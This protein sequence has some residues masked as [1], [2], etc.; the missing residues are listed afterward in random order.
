[1]SGFMNLV[2][3]T[4]KWTLRDKI[5]H[6]FLGSSLVIFL[7][8]P[9]FS[10]FSMRQVQELSITLSLSFTSFVLLVLT[11]LLG[12][13]SV[14]RD[15]EQ[16]YTSSVLGM[17]LSR[18]SFVL[19]KFTGI[20]FFILACAV[21][22][23]AASFFVVA[24]SSAQY[25]SQQP[26]HWGAM[27]IAITSDSLKYVLLAA[28]ALLFSSLSTSF[29]LPFFGTIAMYLAGSG[30]QEVY[31]YIT[32]ELGKDISFPVR[33]ILKALYYA[34]PNFSSFNL[35]VQAIY[36]LPMSFS[37]LS[38]TICYFLIYTAILLLGAIRMFSRRELD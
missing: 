4:I 30:S 35:K 20:S 25:P 19:A 32:S 37:G 2:S 10:L 6:A 11:L 15:I 29:F 28:F 13:S 1:M 18:S 5:L 38:L 23:G 31:E 17:P 24:L 27:I 3:V 33:S 36:G 22:L 14:W 34:L 21:I 7:F 8:V 9:L 16:R 26:V 12:S